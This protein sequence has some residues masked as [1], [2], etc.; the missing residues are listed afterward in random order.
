MG[1]LELKGCLGFVYNALQTSRW[2]NL[3]FT[4]K[5]EEEI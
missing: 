5:F 3:I 1:N 2:Y 4:R